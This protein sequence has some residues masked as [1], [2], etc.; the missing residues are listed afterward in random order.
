MALSRQQADA[1]C[2]ESFGHDMW[3][4]ASSTLKLHSSSHLMFRLENIYEGFNL[5]HYYELIIT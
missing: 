3:E 1:F 2:I 5:H 4:T